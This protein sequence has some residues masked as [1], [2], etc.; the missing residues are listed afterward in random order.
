MIKI[1]RDYESIQNEIDKLFFET[2][3]FRK[4]KNYRDIKNDEK[5]KSKMVKIGKLLVKLNRFEEE[6]RNTR[7]S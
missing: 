5:Y 7:R 6:H 3:N 2:K 4:Y 1:E